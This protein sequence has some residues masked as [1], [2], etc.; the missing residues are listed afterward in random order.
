MYNDVNLPDDEAWVAMLS[1]LRKTKE[2][3]NALSKENS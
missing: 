2:A 1:D 3:R